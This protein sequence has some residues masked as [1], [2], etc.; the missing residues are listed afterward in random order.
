MPR[1]RHTPAG[2]LL[3][4]V[5]KGTPERALRGQGRPR[6]TASGR[7]LYYEAPGLPAKTLRTT[8]PARIRA[9]PAK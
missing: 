3:P 6:R 8:T 7:R 4:G 5:P 1:I 2:V 9:M